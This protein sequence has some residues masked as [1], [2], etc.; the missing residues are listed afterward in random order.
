L[1][2]WVVYQPVT[3]F[4]AP[5]CAN[6]PLLDFYFLNLRPNRYTLLSPDFLV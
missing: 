3:E 1:Y 2:K 4:V 6:Q 5:C